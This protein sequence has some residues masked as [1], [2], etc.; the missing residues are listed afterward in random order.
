M[1]VGTL[2]LIGCYT[3]RFF[4]STGMY[5]TIIS[6]Q[7]TIWSL[8]VSPVAALRLLGLARS[9]EL[10]ACACWAAWS[11]RCRRWQS[12][13]FSLLFLGLEAGAAVAELTPRL[14]DALCALQLVIAGGAWGG[15]VA[16]SCFTDI[17]FVPMDRHLHLGLGHTL[18]S[19]AGRRCLLHELLCHF[20][21]QALLLALLLWRR[22]GQ[23]PEVGTVLPDVAC[24]VGAY[25]SC[26]VSAAVVL[27][28]H[29]L[30]YNLGALP[31]ALQR[32]L[33]LPAWLRGR[34]AA[35][36]IGLLR[37]PWWMRGPEGAE[38]K[39]L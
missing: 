35:G 24:V 6:W 15:M 29:E 26:A 38:G 13:V 32:P 39:G 12:S 16:A 37:L 22:G 27:P 7:L 10:L 14:L 2:L 19:P 33:P 8:H 31:A 36:S 4:D 11:W 17:T 3:H 23:L 21:A 30:P 25:A 20:V 1:H 9:L 5:S 34:G 28:P 18:R